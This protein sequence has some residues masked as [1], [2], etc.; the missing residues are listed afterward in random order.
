MSGLYADNELTRRWREHLT[1]RMQAEQTLRALQSLWR[2][3]PV[4]APKPMQ[5]RR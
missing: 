4:G 3:L 5:V 2:V 1:R